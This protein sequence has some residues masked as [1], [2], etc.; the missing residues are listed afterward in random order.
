MYV[1]FL[2]QQS[3]IV[4]SLENLRTIISNYFSKSDFVRSEILWN[5]VVDSVHDSILVK[6]LDEDATSSVSSVAAERL[7]LCCIVEMKS[8]VL[9]HLTSQTL[10]LTKRLA[11]G[12]PEHETEYLAALRPKL[13]RCLRLCSYLSLRLPDLRHRIEE[14]DDEM[15]SE[16]SDEII[17]VS[18]VES[19]T[20]LTAAYFRLLS[21]VMILMLAFQVK[22]KDER[23]MNLSNFLNLFSS[24]LGAQAPL[25]EAIGFDKDQGSSSLISFR[26]LKIA[27]QSHLEIC[28]DASI[29][30]ELL[31]TLA[32]LSIQLG[33]DAISA[34]VGVSWNALQSEYSNFEAPEDL[35]P[36]YSFRMAAKQ[37]VSL[38]GDFASD[39]NKTEHMLHKAVTKMGIANSS[40]GKNSF[41]AHGMLR[42][43]GLLALS[44]RCSSS[45]VDHLHHLLSNMQTFLSQVREPV[46]NRN[47]ARRQVESSDEDGEYLPPLY[48]RELKVSIPTTSKVRGLGAA[49]FSTYFDTLLQ[50]T[51]ATTS[52]F[53]ISREWELNDMDHPFERFESF[54]EIF[55]SLIKLYEEKLHIFPSKALPAI[56]NSSKH[57]LNVA[58]YQ[59]QRCIE[60]R[61]SQPVVLVHEI[62]AG[63][64]DA[65]SAQHLEELL[66]SVGLHVVGRVQSFCTTVY[67]VTTANS[68][69]EQQ[70]RLKSLGTRNDRL[71]VEL[72][73]IAAAHNVAQPKFDLES[74]AVGASHSR[75]RRR[76]ETLLQMENRSSKPQQPKHDAD[77]K[78]PSPSSSLPMDLDRQSLW[79]EP[80]FDDYASSSHSSDSF[81]ASGHWGKDSD[82]DTESQPGTK[83]KS[84]WVRPS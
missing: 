17:A 13:A 27:F 42:H 56:V 72:L 76:T 2:N 63:R 70:H 36:P 61:N 84:T 77:M 67:S 47:V 28:H 22:S 73:K 41:L 32:I 43:W 53:S 18:T 38:P 29:A 20:T 75:K 37:L 48:Q 7:S 19:L 45:F 64:D 60:W 3:E 51:V 50:M 6:V 1:T 66:D 69:V 44:P 74:H 10:F 33:D 59:V 52:M 25:G 21:N 11:V 4:S 68:H 65:A 30:S 8:K 26:S 31:E 9:E 79:S 71:K 16:T 5:V 62:H 40:S 34:M 81:G 58:S 55:G 14:A 82:D 39:S 78:N 83:L 35:S 46:V 54:V 23:F 15:V 57:M 80:S 24:I 12:V 49:S